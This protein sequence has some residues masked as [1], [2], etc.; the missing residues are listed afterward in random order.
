MFQ[1]SFHL[2][3]KKK[4]QV[5]CFR[6]LN[7]IITNN[8]T[9]SRTI[10]TKFIKVLIDYGLAIIVKSFALYPRVVVSSNRSNQSLNQIQKVEKLNTILLRLILI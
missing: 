7:L 5:N 6:T 4:Q 2:S 9:H 3:Q 10:D 1:I 8:T